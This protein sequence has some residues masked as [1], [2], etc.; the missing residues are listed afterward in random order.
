MSVLHFDA[1]TDNYLSDTTGNF[2]SFTGNNDTMSFS[3]VGESTIMAMGNN[4]AIYVTKVGT[5]D[6]NLFLMG[7]NEQLVFAYLFADTG[8]S[9]GDFTVWGMN[10]S[11]NVTLLP[12]QTAT[13]TPDHHGGTFLTIGAAGEPAS[14]S[15]I[16]FAYAP[17]VAVV[18]TV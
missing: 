11:D 7:K 10:A 4:Q 15:T 14:A 12:F 2:V 3:A 1:T 17:H 6:D 8:I 16:H 9:A 13:A 18:S 5:C